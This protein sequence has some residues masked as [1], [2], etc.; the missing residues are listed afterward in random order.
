MRKTAVFFI[1]LVFVSVNAYSFWIWSPKT[2]KWKNPKYSPLATPFLQY[3]QAAKYFNEKDYKNAY[4]SFKKMLASYPDAKEAADAQYYLGATL[5]KLNKPYAAYL[6]YKKVIDSYPNSKRINDVVKKEYSIG[7]YF[8]NRPRKKWL[9]VSMYDFV[10][11]PSI[12]IFRNIVDKSP[13][14]PYAPKAQYKLG[15]LFLQ[16]ARYDEAKDAFQKII[17]NYPETKW[18][19]PAKYQLAI[20]ASKLFAGADYDSTALK[21]ATDRLKEFIK[22]HPDADITPQAKEQFKELK[23]KEA[24]K[25]FGIAQ[26]YEK[27]KKY[28]AAAIYYK[29]VIDN[30]PDSKYASNAEDKLKEINTR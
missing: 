17:D 21:E 24:E 3:K 29:M 4:K 12:E 23:N 13:Y 16:L 28:K 11:H 25:N 7:E 5:E 9:G 6:E 27:Q 10:E 14:S 2:Q 22:N 26:F 15:F 18:A 20:A 19:Y 30:Y 8:L 1:F